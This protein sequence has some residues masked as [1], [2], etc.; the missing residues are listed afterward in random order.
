VTYRVSNE[1]IRARYAAIATDYAQRVV[2]GKVPAC[3]WVRL[4]CER[5]LRDLERA[6]TEDFPYVFNPELVDAKGKPVMIKKDV[7]RV[8]ILDPATG[9]GT[10]L[11]ETIK[12]IAAQVKGVAEGM[13][14]SYVERDLIPRLHGFE[15]LMASYAMCHMKLDMMLTDM[16]Y[17]PS[18]N[19]P[20]LGVY[21]TNSLEEGERVEQTLPFA[22]WLSEE[23]KGANTIK[24][25]TPIMC[26]IGNPPYS[27]ISQNMG[28]WIVDK[29]EDYKYVGGAHFGERKHWLHDDYVKF[30]RMAEHMI[31]KN[32]EG[33]LGFITNHGYLDNP[34]FRG[35]RHHL[36]QTYARPYE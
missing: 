2:D 15:L 3:K 26:V 11:A 32:G 19:P 27:G 10:F 23:S 25:D 17:K 21:L 12:Q 31:D 22:R 4:A 33:I 7:H 1:E 34:T 20:R 28:S 24:R 8:Q 35:M 13:W 36:L 29:I 9:T 30:I 5:H 18:A 14:S 16:G 6:G